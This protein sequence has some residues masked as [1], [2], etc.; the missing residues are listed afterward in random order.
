[1]VSCKLSV[2]SGQ[3]S[4][5]SYYS[6]S[7]LGAVRKTPN[8]LAPFP[9]REGGTGVLLPSPRRRGGVGRGVNLYLIQ[10]RI[11]ILVNKQPTTNNQQLT[12]SFSR[13]N[14]FP[15]Y[16]FR[17]LEIVWTSLSPRPEQL[18]TM[19]GLPLSWGPRVSK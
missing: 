7:Q 11:A 17:N 6:V 8:P 14:L 13:V 2:V 1:M 12:T 9:I 16:K 19:R 5:V 15:D 10:M 18:M 3:L 4:V